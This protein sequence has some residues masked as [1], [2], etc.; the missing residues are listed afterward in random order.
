MNPL[1]ALLAAA[2]KKPD[3]AVVEKTPPKI[4]ASEI[5]VM[6]EKKPKPSMKRQKPIPAAIVEEV[7]VKHIDRSLSIHNRPR[8]CRVNKKC[9]VIADCQSCIM[10][11][12]T[13]RAACVRSNEIP[14][15]IK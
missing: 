3:G 5:E 9:R 7:A 2:K 12:F 6:E 8:Y 11:Q 13:H 4:K 10:Q 1:E 14:E 15:P